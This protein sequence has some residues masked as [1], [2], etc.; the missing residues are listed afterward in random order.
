[1]RV[2][3]ALNVV[4]IKTIVIHWAHVGWSADDEPLAAVDIFEV[5]L[6]FLFNAFYKSRK[7]RATELYVCGFK[8]EA[9]GKESM[10]AIQRRQD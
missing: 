10:G 5:R 1:M 3:G 7:S 6:S 2:A 4:S 9:S 8:K